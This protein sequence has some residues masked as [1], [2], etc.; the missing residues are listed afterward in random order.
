MIIWSMMWSAQN[1]IRKKKQQ[2]DQKNYRN[3]FSSL[4]YYVNFILHS[5]PEF[6]V[7][8]FPLLFSFNFFL[9][10]Y[11]SSHLFIIALCTPIKFYLFMLSLSLSIFVFVLLVC[12][13]LVCAQLSKTLLV[14]VRFEPINFVTHSSFYV[15]TFFLFYCDLRIIFIFFFPTSRSGMWCPNFYDFAICFAFN[16]IGK[17]YDAPMCTH[18]A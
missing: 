6:A 13:S 2:Q 9:P 1:E 3:N 11:L 12:L 7:C 4:K 17:M 5:L 18:V 14:S 8:R 10:L 16:T 15:T